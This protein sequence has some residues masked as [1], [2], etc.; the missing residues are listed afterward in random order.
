MQSSATTVSAYLAELPDDRRATIDAVRTVL[1]ECLDDAF[2][3][4]MQ[5]GM[6]GY[7]VPYAIYPPGYHCEP[8]Q[9]LP[10]AALASQKNY[11]SL[12][13]M[14]VYSTEAERERFQA[15][16]KRTGKRLD[17]GKSCTRFRTIDDLALDVIRDAVRR[18]SAQDYIK[19][20]ESVFR[21]STKAERGAPTASTSKSA[22]ANSAKTRPAATVKNVPAKKTSTKKADAKKAATKRSRKST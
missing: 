21:P 1:R 6:I 20:Y 2:E 9:P 18:I 10:F 8:R 13:L 5:Y 17:M 22:A 11:C 16:W 7:Y 4:G 19:I 15:E 3:E 12:Y 14:S